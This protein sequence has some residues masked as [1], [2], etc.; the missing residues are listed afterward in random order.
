M[1][2]AGVEDSGRAESNQVGF[3]A[4]GFE[5]L[6]IKTKQSKKKTDSNVEFLKSLEPGRR[7]LSSVESERIVSVLDDCI[8]KVEIVTLLPFIIENVDRFSLLLGSELVSLIQEYDII[9]RNYSKTLKIRRKA[10]RAQSAAER[11]SEHSEDQEESSRPASQLS[12]GADWLARA[13]L[14]E[15]EYTVENL[16]GAMKGTIKTIVRDFGKNPS[17]LKAINVERKERAFEANN[18]IDG[19]RSLKDLVFLRLVT[20][21]GEDLERVKQ[22]VDLTVKERKAQANIVKLSANLAA[23]IKDRDEEIEKQ[24]DVIKNLKT[25]IH[26]VEKNSEDQNH[27]IV[28][29]AAKAES[30]ELKNSDGKKT[31]LQQEIIQSKQSLKNN[32]TSHRESELSLRKRKYKIETEVE[33]WIQK[34]DNDMGERQ[35]EFDE[36]DTIYTEEKRQLKELE[37]RFKTLDEEYTVI[38]EERRVARERREAAE[39]ELRSAIKAATVLQSFWRAYKMRKALKT[40]KKKKGKK[41]KKGKGKRKR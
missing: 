37:E 23:A 18:F 16:R 26:N 41:G 29:D 24:N 35:D 20:S 4:N 1:A 6:Q 10:L 15:L 30:G 2:A 32:L 28:A 17:A 14:E 21:P 9:E 13:E 39:Q 12:Y 34:F 40:K 31:K 38:M 36:L 11:A 22:F 19:L 25:S 27:K 3:L 7:K 33:N 5:E 8:R